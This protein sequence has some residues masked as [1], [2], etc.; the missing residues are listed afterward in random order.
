VSTSRVGERREAHA[1][2][3]FVV[4]GGLAA[5]VN[6]VSRYLLS[7][8]LTFEAAVAVAFVLAMTTA[9]LLNRAFV[10]RSSAHWL[11]Q[12]WRFAVVNLI[13]F[14]QVF[15]VSEGL[16]RLLFPAVG[17]RWHPLEIGHLLGVMSPIATSYYAHKHFTFRRA[18]EADA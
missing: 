13:A 6:V 12:Y 15:L 8:W 3:A 10:F 16:V 11:T 7:R 1:F 17:L 4:S 5:G 9:F 18:P 2:A 14:V